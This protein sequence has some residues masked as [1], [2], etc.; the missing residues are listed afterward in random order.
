MGQMRISGLISG[1]DTETII[2]QLVSAKRLKVTKATGE[3]TK[4]SW[5]QD[6]WKD[7]N[8]DLQKLHTSFSAKLRFATAY[9]QKK[10]TVSNT[11]VASVIAGAGA[12]DSV[13]EL[14][15]SQ[16][17]KSAYFTGGKLSEDKSYTALTTLKEL[18]ISAGKTLSVSTSEETLTVTDETT[19]SDLLTYYKNAGLNASFDE[20]NQRLFVSA[21][22]TGADADFSFGGDGTDL[23]ALGL[24]TKDSDYYKNLT[25]EEKAKVALGTK[26]DGQDAKITLNGA[27]FTSSTNVFSVNGLTITA[28]NETKDD[29]VVTLTTSNDTDGIYD[30]V[31]DFLKQYNTVVNKI[32]KLYSAESVSKYE[33]LT[34]DEKEA[35]SDTEVE[36]YEDKIKEG[37]LRGDNTLNSI[38]SALRGIMSSGFEVNGTKMYLSAFGISTGDYFTT[39]DNEKHALHI[40]GDSDDSLTSGKEDKLKSMI[41]S[42]PDSVISFFTQL[43]KSLYSKMNDLSKSQSGYR[44]YG[45]FYNDIKMK[46]DYSDYKTKIAELE[47]KANDYEDKLYSKFSAMETA[48]AKLQSSTS[49]ITGLMGS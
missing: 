15:V 39:E 42:D 49:A 13:Q 31:K 17:A 14:Q 19:I 24:L 8:S 43:S 10:T 34:D 40:D 20:N 12:T 21:K 41:A 1:M 27:E 26:I 16:L 35:M 29:E 47:E 7:L 4:L 30:L 45:T 44:T 6:I 37:L 18:G 5:K 28:L 22:T 25:D 2:E 3:Q 33:M 36:K 38:G 9:Q 32:D 23:A 11:S 48:L 46:S